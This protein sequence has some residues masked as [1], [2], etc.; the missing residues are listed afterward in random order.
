VPK[1]IN[2]KSVTVETRG[3][4]WLWPAI[5]LAPI[6][7]SAYQVAEWIASIM[8]AILAAASVT[9]AAA[10][11]GCVAL[12]Y[13]HRGRT[14]LDAPEWVIE[15]L[16]APRIASHGAVPDRPAP[17]ITAQPQAAIEAPTV[18]YHL[19]LHAAPTTQPIAI[20]ESK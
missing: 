11:T 1:F 7:Y 16:D 8:V 3:S 15:R 4:G 10:V 13:Q 12:L 5:V 9:A 18:H 17:A 20:E 14:H 2:P 19:H 6:V